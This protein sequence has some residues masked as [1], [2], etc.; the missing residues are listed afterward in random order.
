VSRKTRPF[1]L[2]FAGND[3]HK[4]RRTKGRAERMTEEPQILLSG[5]PEFTNASY[6]SQTYWR[7]IS[8]VRLLISHS[9]A[10]HHCNT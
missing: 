10:K 3:A 8:L 9:K 5:K 7:K 1:L 4:K 2:V 6:F